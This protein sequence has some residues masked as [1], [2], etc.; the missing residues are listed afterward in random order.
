MSNNFN[1]KIKFIN[2]KYCQVF[3]FLLLITFLSAGIPDNVETR[4]QVFV[5]YCKG[6]LISLNPLRTGSLWECTS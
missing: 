4:L 1:I 3:L 2:K 6:A 5:M